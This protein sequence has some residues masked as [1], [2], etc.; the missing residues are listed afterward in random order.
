[1]MFLFD[2]AMKLIGTKQTA[3]GGYRLTQ[4]RTSQRSVAVALL[5]W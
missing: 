3:G 2:R 4:A 1:M 5:S